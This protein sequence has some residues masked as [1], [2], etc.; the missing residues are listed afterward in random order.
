MNIM[1]LVLSIAILDIQKYEDLLSVN[2]VW[3]FLNY[4]K[5]ETNFCFHLDIFI[6]QRNHVFMLSCSS[7]QLQQIVTFILNK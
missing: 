5:P 6:A 1:N 2:S 4:C 3:Q 7:Q